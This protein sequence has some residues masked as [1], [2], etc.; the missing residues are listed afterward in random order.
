[1]EMFPECTKRRFS[2]LFVFGF[3]SVLFLNKLLS[4]VVVFCVLINGPSAS[5]NVLENSNSKEGLCFCCCVSNIL[6]HHP[7]LLSI[8]APTPP[9][10]K[11]ETFLSLSLLLTVVYLPLL[12]FSHICRR[13]LRS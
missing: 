10:P 5:Q 11:G 9:V 6:Y 4:C 2:F 1:M 7:G 3:F 8:H 13:I 12:F